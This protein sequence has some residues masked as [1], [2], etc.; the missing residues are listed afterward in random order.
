MTSP[1]EKRHPDTQIPFEGPYGG[2]SKMQWARLVRFIHSLLQ[3]SLYNNQQWRKNPATAKAIGSCKS[4]AWYKVVIG[5]KDIP[6][7]PLNCHCLVL[8]PYL[9]RI[10]VASMLDKILLK[11]QLNGLTGVSGTTMVPRAGNGWSK[12]QRFRICRRSLHR[13]QVHGGTTYVAS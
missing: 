2:L 3:E 12:Q 10:G 5:Q 7:L 6:V 4:E 11:T 8:C 1:S 13:S 9:L